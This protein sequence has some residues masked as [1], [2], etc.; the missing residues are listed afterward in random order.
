MLQTYARAA[1]DGG[2]EVVTAATF[3]TASLYQDFGKA[4]MDSQR[5]K[6]LKPAELEQYNVMLEEQAFPFEEKAADIHTTNAQRAAEGVYDTWVQQSFNA[7]RSLRPVRFGKTERADNASG[8]AA[9]LNRQAIALR[10]QGKFKDAREAWQQAL[11]ASPE[12]APAVLN[13]GVLLDLY[14]AEP[15]QALAQYEQYLALTPAGDAQVA[16]WVAELKNRKPA[17]RKES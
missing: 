4:L 12:Y 3:H 5:P 14:L 7:L 13:L 16:K 6:K 8:T 17:P 15:T 9:D 1:E 11:A 10:Q 2:A